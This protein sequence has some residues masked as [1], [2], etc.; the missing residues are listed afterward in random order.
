LRDLNDSINKLLREKRHWENRIRELGG[1]HH[2]RTGAPRVD[3]SGREVVGSRGYKYFGAAKDLPGVR[4]LFSTEPPLIP[5]KT[6]AELMSGIDADYY[7][8]R[9]E[10]NGLILI[11][12]SEAQKEE[13]IKTLEIENSNK[14]LNEILEQRYKE[15]QEVEG[16]E[17]GLELSG[18]PKR[19]LS[20]VPSIPS[21][22]DVRNELLERKKRELINKY[23][24][25]TEMQTNS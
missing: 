23:L 12:E 19:F 2:R 21:Q 18:G 4:E 24:T 5:R 17:A 20:H 15:Q 10:D 25:D 7:G 8:F 6:R 1:I 16:E 22:E 9:D 3:S 11:G 13:I 14:T